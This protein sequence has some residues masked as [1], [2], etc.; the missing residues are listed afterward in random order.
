VRRKRLAKRL[1]RG[2]PIAIRLAP[3]CLLYLTPTAVSVYAPGY[4]ARTSSRRKVE[5]IRRAL[6][7]WLDQGK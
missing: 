7:A 6:T 1:R 2:G 4:M 3:D 5:R